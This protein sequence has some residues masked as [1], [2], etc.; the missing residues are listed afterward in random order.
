MTTAVERLSAQG[1]RYLQVSTYLG[2]DG[3]GLS[4]ALVDAFG[5]AELVIRSEYKFQ[6]LG[7]TGDRQDT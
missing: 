4:S 7:S 1:L 6:M 2:E 3:S 5:L